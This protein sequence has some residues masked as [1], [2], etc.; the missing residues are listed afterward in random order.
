MKEIKIRDL[1]IDDQD[2]FAGDKLSRKAEIENLTE[3][4]LNVRTPAVFAI[5]SA[6]G[7]GKSTFVKMWQAY[8]KQKGVRVSVYFNAW[9]TDYAADPLIAFLGEMNSSLQEHLKDEWGGNEAW[10]KVKIIG[11]HIAKRS[12]PVLVKLGT[13]GLIDMDQLVE[14]DLS[15]LSEGLT[16]DSIKAYD[17]S[18]SEIKS[19]K[20]NLNAVVDILNEQYPVVVFVDELDRCRPT[21]AIELLERI[22]H[23]LDIENLLFV[24]SIDKKQLCHCIKSVY[25]SG[26][27]SI[28]YLRRF[29]DIEYNLKK[30]EVGPYIETL[31]EAFDFDGFFEKRKQYNAFAY[32]REH[33]SNVFILLAN[34]FGFTIREIQQILSKINLAIL[35]TR[36]NEYLH[37]A[38]L[39]FLIVVKEVNPTLY[40][41]YVKDDYTP[42]NVIDFLYSKFITSDRLESFECALIEG[43]LINAKNSSYNSKIGLSLEKHQKVLENTESSR[44]ERNYSDWVVNVAKGAGSSYRRIALDVLV[45][46]IEMLSQFNHAGTG[47]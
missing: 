13:A 16:K 7:T 30:P 29:I 23:I 33:L 36:E 41:E 27:D 1:V 5:D 11:S 39:S 26:I 17:D 34:V 22:K 44:E 12:L 42:E 43:Y 40:E 38:L 28:G 15:A 8:L 46:K 35:A 31:Y 9:E 47:S 25:G 21:Y 19:F 32:E 18:K 4:L 45:N 37:P 10:S 24:I 6:W 3:L 2:P 20:E 14:K